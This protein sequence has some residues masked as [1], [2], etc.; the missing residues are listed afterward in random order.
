MQKRKTWFSILLLLTVL[1]VSILPV[2]A[3]LWYGR[4]VRAEGSETLGDP[5][6]DGVLE[7]ES[8]ENGMNDGIDGNTG[9]E[10]LPEMSNR[11]EDAENGI[12]N[13]I[14]DILDGMGDS[15]KED[16]TDT[17]D[18]KT[19]DLP[20]NNVTKAVTDSNNSDQTPDES[21]SF[22]WAFFTICLLIAA[23]VVAVI[24]L[25]T[26]KGSGNSNGQNNNEKKS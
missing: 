16:E 8:L 1:T 17:T 22:N 12:E 23:A 6:G 13:G 2:S 9:D 15:D 14:D 7:D 11:T 5:D 19:T 18:G 24:V 3:D 20:E 10:K 4:S 25:L 21:S 26:S